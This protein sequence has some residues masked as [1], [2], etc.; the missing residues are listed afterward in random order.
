MRS[1]ERKEIIGFRSM[2]LIAAL[3]VAIPM[4]V[5]APLPADAQQDAGARLKE[6]EKNLKESRE[7]RSE[8]AEKADATQREIRTIAQEL[9]RRTKAV[10]DS[11]EKVSDVETRIADLASKENAAK[12]ALDSQSAHMAETLAA[13]QRLSQRPPELM[14][15][16]PEEAVNTVR[17][18]TLMKEALPALRVQAENIR[19]SMDEI[20]ALR[21]TL[22]VERDSLTAELQ[23]L[24][25]RVA[26]LDRVKKRRET[27]RRKLVANANQ[28]TKRVKTLTAEAETLRGLIEKIERQ[29]KA[30]PDKG[31]DLS[32]PGGQ[33]F[34]SARGE[35]VTPARGPVVQRF[36]AKTSAGEAR[37]IRIRTRA[38][39]QVVAPFDG[40]VIF[41]GPF[42][43]YGQLLIIAHGE[44]Y[45]TLIA[46][47]AHIEANVGQ[48][49]LTGE[50]VGIMKAALG[51]SAGASARKAAGNEFPE[52]Y[53]EIRR[54][55]D[56]VNP[57]P[58]LAKG[59]GKVG[60]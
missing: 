50:P 36:G 54:N 41:S 60:G 31:P 40:R 48:W 17:S 2:R 4:M 13:L 38:S 7:R 56:P 28:E 9:V 11:E 25:S 43:S 12:A 44:G 32:V 39:A 6:V 33:A 26:S 1:A 42:R 30:A 53:L 21:G 51:T 18:A 34:A 47:M 27:L 15:A 35:L 14:M 57:T 52:L 23:D 37:G 19:V 46:G 20:E 10:Q 24:Q 59:S 3:G 22:Q 58:W 29:R 8:L 55:G 5:L 45:H 16:R 49:I